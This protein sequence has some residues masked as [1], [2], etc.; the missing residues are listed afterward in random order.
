MDE[1]TPIIDT[2]AAFA[3]GWR[4]AAAW[5]NRSDL[6]ADVDSPAYMRER[7]IALAQ[8]ESNRTSASLEQRDKRSRGCVD[9]VSAELPHYGAKKQ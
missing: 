5:A 6:L 4:Q 3:A 1:L 7:D 8:I 2:Q 9:I